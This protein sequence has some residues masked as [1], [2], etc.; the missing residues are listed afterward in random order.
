MAAVL[1]AAG[2]SSRLGTNKLLL[3]L[4]GEPVVR[5]AA[6][7]ALAARL[8]P[9]IIVLGY[10]AEAVAGAVAGLPVETVLNPR[11]AEGMYRSVETGVARV[12]SHCRA[13]VVILP[14][15][16]LVTAAMLEQVAGRFEAGAP[17]V[18]SRYGGVEAPPTLYARAL[19]PALLRAGPEVGRRVIREHRGR[20]DTLDWPADRLADLDRPEDLARVRAL[21]AGAT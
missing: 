2:S 12:P 14:D 13:A 18:V 10:E 3:E 1:P 6:R 21:L 4:N 15:M 20:T 5:G 11:H 7:R 17:L 16:P 9:V 8:S 19:F